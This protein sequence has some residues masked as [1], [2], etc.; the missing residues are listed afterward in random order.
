MNPTPCNGFFADSS[1][2]P[3]LSAPRRRADVSRDGCRG[4]PMALSRDHRIDPRGLRRKRNGEMHV[5]GRLRLCTRKGS[6]RGTHAAAPSHVSLGVSLR[7]K[8][9]L[10]GTRAGSS[11]KGVSRLAAY[12][13]YEAAIDSDYNMFAIRHTHYFAKT[14]Q[15][16]NHQV[17][18]RLGNY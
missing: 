8:F 9:V 10:R 2:G 12:L 14:N 3:D 6:A 7:P 11:L 13:C 15:N 1:Q 5:S 16:L 17:N 18:T 4:H